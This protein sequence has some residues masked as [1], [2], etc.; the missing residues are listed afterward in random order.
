VVPERT[1]TAGF[2]F[3]FEIIKFFLKSYAETFGG[4]SNEKKFMNKLATWEHQYCEG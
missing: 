3:P 4:N 1:Q 2:G